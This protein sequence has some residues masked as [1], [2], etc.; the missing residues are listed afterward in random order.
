MLEVKSLNNK[1]DFS[2]LRK[3]G[4]RNNSNFVT[5]IT[6]TYKINDFRLGFQINTKTGNAVFRNRIRRQ[7]KHILFELFDKYDKDPS[8]KGLWILVSVNPKIEK[9]DFSEYKSFLEKIDL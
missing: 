3:Y 7:I 9:F 6:L 5:L 2:K 1:S 4:K 8:K